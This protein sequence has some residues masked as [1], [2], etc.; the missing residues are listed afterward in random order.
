MISGAMSTPDLWGSFGVAGESA[1]L[2]ADGVLPSSGATAGDV[3]DTWVDRVS[4]TGLNLKL[5]I[6]VSRVANKLKSGSQVGLD[7]GMTSFA[8]GRWGT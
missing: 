8:R 2:K 6:E 3:V 7:V 4:S 1:V 5:E